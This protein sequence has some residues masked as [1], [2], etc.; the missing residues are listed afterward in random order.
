MTATAT[1]KRR[2]T[3]A[4]TRTGIPRHA[5]DIQVHKGKSDVDGYEWGVDVAG[6]VTLG[7]LKLLLANRSAVRIRSPLRMT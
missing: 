6:E 3:N 4:G 1:R 2:G 7:G 5:R